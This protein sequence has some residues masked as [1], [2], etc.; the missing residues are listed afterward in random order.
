VN[1]KNFSVKEKKEASIGSYSSARQ[2]T[3]TSARSGAHLLQIYW[4][5]Y[6]YDTDQATKFIC[7]DEGWL[8]CLLTH[9]KIQSNLWDFRWPPERFAGMELPTSK[10]SRSSHPKE[11]ACADPAQARRGGHRETSGY[12]T[13]RTYNEMHCPK[14]RDPLIPFAMEVSCVSSGVIQKPPT[15]SPHER[16]NKDRFLPMP[17]KPAEV[18]TK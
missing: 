8:A 12:F 15:P 6:V 5:N 13:G 7:S 9:G 1:T 2:G 18:M 14:R 10:H 16:A 3:S 17:H 11:V 4:I